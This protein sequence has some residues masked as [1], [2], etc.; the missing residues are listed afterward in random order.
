MYRAH[1]YP[2]TALTAL[3]LSEKRLLMQAGVIA[4]DMLPERRS[5][6]QDIHIPSERI[7][8]ILAEGDALCSLE[9]TEPSFASEMEEDRSREPII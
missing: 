5:A 1:V 6:L 7:G 4:C 3:K 9:Y 2:I 8:E